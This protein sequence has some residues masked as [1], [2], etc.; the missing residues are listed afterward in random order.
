MCWVVRGTKGT[1][2]ECVEEPPMESSLAMQAEGTFAWDRGF[3]TQ[4]FVNSG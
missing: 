2:K 4:Q 3:N 1:G